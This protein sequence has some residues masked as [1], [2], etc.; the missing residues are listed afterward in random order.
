MADNGYDGSIVIN[1]ELDNDG[2]EKGSDKLLSAVTD[3]AKQVNTL[4]AEMKT[5]FSG[6][7]SILQSMAA[8]A[9]K[10]AANTGGSTEQA[11]RAA[12]AS[13]RSSQAQA[14]AA[15]QSA[16]T[17]TQA[18][19]H[20]AQ[21]H[22]KTAESTKAATAATQNFDKELGKLQKK[23]A[24]AKAG[25]SDYYAELENIKAET[26]VALRQSV[27]DEQARNTLEIEQIQIDNTNKKYAKKL[28]ILKQLEDE[29]KKLAAA[30]DNA[31]KTDSDEQAQQQ[32]SGLAGALKALSLAFRENVTD[33]KALDA[34]GKRVVAVFGD[35]GRKVKTAT[36]QLLKLPFK[37]IAA[38]AKLAMAGL[39]KFAKQAEKTGLS[40]NGLVKSLTSLK[41]MLVA[42][43]KRMFISSIFNDVGEG[44]KQLALFDSRF[45][46]TMSN[47][48]NSLT[49]LKGNI[50]AVVGNMLS[51][52]EPIITAIINLM[53]KAV[54]A[55]NQFFAVLNGKS[56]YTAAKKGNEQFAESAEDAAEAQKKFN[57]ELY[58]FDELNRQNKP[59]ASSTTDL[60]ESAIQFE[61]LP[62]DLPESVQKWVEDLKSAWKN[63]DWDGVGEVL[64]EGLNA[65]LKKADDWINNTLRPKGVEWAN[66]AAE[67]LNG[68]FD[69]VDWPLLG[70]TVADG[71]NA[72]AD[73]VNTF[74]T[75]FK[76]K[77]FGSGIGA[78][79][80]SWFDNIDWELIGQTFANKW[81]LLLH[82]IEGISFSDVCSPF[83]P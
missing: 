83:C 48:K 44:L 69:N 71:L 10:A 31:N 32:A 78:A 38:S 40:T 27:T 60:D 45:N 64:A 29:Y 28:E 72:I 56:T 67:I 11:T 46:A 55:V 43:I 65:T 2:F 49:Q 25:L 47:M 62:V 9:N 15:K 39:K 6:I 22:N 76:A 30:R 16:K 58:S 34:A 3:V 51:A 80:K 61:E 24:T 21:A 50:S 52:L 5:A 54:T 8:A 14:Q 63:A 37:A 7:T 77:N 74:F 66:R 68:L 42:R 18:A 57:N 79:I 23:I 81:N 17:Q 13:Q 70:K 35:M 12:E 73:I 82:T 1:T 4:G 19:Q 33:E 59:D 53:N 75:T 41:T 20:T 26:D 36:K